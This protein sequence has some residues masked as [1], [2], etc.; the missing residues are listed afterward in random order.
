MPVLYF[1][2]NVYYITR[3]KTPCRLLPF[4]VPALTV[5]TKQYLSAFV[6][7]MP[8]IAATRFKCYIVYTDSADI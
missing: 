6:V 5:S 1:R 4:L 8:V 2:L 7:N 3:G